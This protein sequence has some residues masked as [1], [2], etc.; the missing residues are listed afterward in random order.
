MQERSVYI[1]R[2]YIY[3]IISTRVASSCVNSGSWSKFA[4]NYSL[5]IFEFKN[6]VYEFNK[7]TKNI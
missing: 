1:F 6:I 2:Y 7:V 4:Q 5:R 3:N